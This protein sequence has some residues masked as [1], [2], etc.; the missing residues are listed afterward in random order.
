MTA[1][2]TRA[3][4]YVRMSTEP[5]HLSIGM[6]DAANRAY[7]D[8]HGLEIVAT[9]EDPGVSGLTL[10]QRPGLKALLADVVAGSAPFQAILVSDVSR[11]G[12]FQDP[13]EAAHYE[14]LCRAAGVRVHY[15]AEAFANDDSLPSVLVKQLKRMMA[16]EFVRD[17]SEKIRR[18]HRHLHSLGVFA[19]GRPPYGF[20][21]QQVGPDLC[22]QKL[23]GP[24]E[25]KSYVA[26]RIVL[27]PGPPEAVA[28]VRKV[29]R[30]FIRGQRTTSQIVRDLNADTTVRGART[31]TTAA[32]RSLLRNEV[33]AGALVNG[34][35]TYFLRRRTRVPQPEWQRMVGAVPPIVSRATWQ[36]AQALLARGGYS[37]HVSNEALLS[38]LHRV[39]RRLG[40]LSVAAIKGAGRFP[41]G[42]YTARFGSPTRAYLEAGLK[43][44]KVRRARPRESYLRKPHAYTH[45]EIL[46][47]VRAAFIRE[48]RLTSRIINEDRNCARTP[49]L[50]THFGGLRLVYA[51]VGYEPTTYQEL[52]MQSRGQSITRGQAI[53]IRQAAQSGWSASDLL[54]LASEVALSAKAYAED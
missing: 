47:G 25:K 34:K 18:V 32:V 30:D 38:D 20:M 33:Y 35:E 19:G 15:T 43:P 16:A 11:W 53:S 54:A 41:V 44:W 12:R 21:R 8:A 27:T 45:E 2:L 4:Q 5:Q 36:K 9:Y 1:E 7:A 6:Q 48:G 14:F 39:H 26:S 24:G 22:P 28:V 40:Y 37:R 13:D 31:W 29:F 46:A 50:Q 10:E 49:A 17:H 51:L 3:A 42:L 23:L 52:M